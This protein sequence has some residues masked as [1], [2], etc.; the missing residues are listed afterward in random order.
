MIAEQEMTMERA[1]RV[2]SRLAAAALLV[3]ALGLHAPV[4]G[5]ET[6]AVPGSQAAVFNPDAEISSASVVVDG[7]V[8]FPVSGTSVY[9]AEKR[10]SA[11]AKRIV[12]VAANPSVPAE[13]IRTVEVE[14][15]TVIVATGQPLVTVLDAD[16]RLVSEDRQRLAETIV[17]NIRM[18]VV[19]YRQARSREALT[20]S[21]GR[22]AVAT[23]V[24]VAFVALV[25]WLSRRLVAALEKSQESRA[26]PAGTRPF[27]IFHAGQMMRLLRKLVHGVRTIVVVA[28]GY[29][30]LDFVLRLLPW[31]R[32]ISKSLAG[33]VI[34]PLATLAEQFVNAIPDL[35]FLIVLYF[36]TRA[37]LKFIRMFFAAVERGEVKLLDFEGEWAVP[38]YKL[39]RIGV[40][41][42]ALVVAYPY[43]PGSGTDAFKGISIFVG[44][45]FSLGSSTAIAKLIAGYMLT[46]RRAFRVG[47]RIKIGDMK[48][49]VTELRLQATHLKTVWNELVTIPN[50][51]ILN[52]EVV[53]YSSLARAGQLILHTTVGVGYGTPWRQVEAMLLMAAERT[54]GLVKEPS[55]FVRLRQE[56]LSEFAVNYEIDVY[57]DNA[58]AMG[59]LYT[60][61]NFNILDVFNEYGVQIM[62]PAYQED[63]EPPKVVPKEEWF[64][65]PARPANADA[66]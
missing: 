52:D 11:V 22:G 37:L 17:Q 51:K 2:A 61:L 28:A 15:G 60:R 56:A 43:V 16:A 31:T 21:A 47:D 42:L 58:Q 41:V 40:I 20:D 34:D 45:V 54:P 62:V 25:I 12:A 6:D 36:V 66:K 39:V 1:R 46:Y 24:L 18:A 57:C 14:Y 5:A 7:N 26:W 29:V 59:V 38:T 4:L 23:A 65:M 27:Q 63:T 30:Y 49:D 19:D 35:L 8:L 9:P 50:S 32:G 3:V 13:A 55:P 53:N 10:A 33:Y 64:R 44:I 48:G